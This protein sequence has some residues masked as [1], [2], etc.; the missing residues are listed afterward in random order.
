MVTGGRFCLAEKN[1]IK[2][3][4]YSSECITFELQTLK[5]DNNG[6]N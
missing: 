6:Q 3:L 4:E 1:I 2:N 5:T